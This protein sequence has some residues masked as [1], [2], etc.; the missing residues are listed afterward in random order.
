MKAAVVAFDQ[1]LEILDRAIPSPGPT[2]VL[3]RMRAAG[4]L[5]TSPYFAI[6]RSHLSQV[7]AAAEDLTRTAYAAG[8]AGAQRPT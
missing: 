4:N 5:R 7:A 1:P 8:T 6:F 3:I 2:Q